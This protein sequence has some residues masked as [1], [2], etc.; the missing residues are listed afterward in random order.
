MRSKNIFTEDENYGYLNIVDSKN[1]EHIFIFDK[2]YIERIKSFH[3]TYVSCGQKFG[4]ARTIIDNK[5]VL[6]HRFLY[7]LMHD[8]ESISNKQIDHKNGNTLDNTSKNLRICNPQ[9]NAR[10]TIYRQKPQEGNIIGVRKDKRCKNSWRAQIYIDKNKKIEKTYKDKELAIVQR[11]VWE[12]VYFKDFAPQIA[13]IKEKYPYLLGYETI[14][15]KMSFS[16][17]INLIKKIGD[18]LLQDKHCPCSLVKTPN[19]ICPCE[20]CRTKQY[21]HCGIFIPKDEKVEL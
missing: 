13:L 1:I 21:C 20:D 15:D 19:T 4:Y 9:E 2:I 10:N 6:L 5:I 3:W 17:D 18:K 7:S 14:C 16:E 11:L 12:L 8:K